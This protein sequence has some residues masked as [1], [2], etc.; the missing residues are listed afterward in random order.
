MIF[1]FSPNTISISQPILK[2]HHKINLLIM[3]AQACKCDVSS[4][5][6]WWM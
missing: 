5:C 1:S 6:W 4:W 2:I 3:W